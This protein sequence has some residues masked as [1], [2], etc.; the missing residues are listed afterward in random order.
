MTAL[1]NELRAVMTFLACLSVTG[2]SAPFDDT[3]SRLTRQA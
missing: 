2:S 1:F 3:D